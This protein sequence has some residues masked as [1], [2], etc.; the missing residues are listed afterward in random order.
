MIDLKIAIEK[1]EEE[2]KNDELCKEVKNRYFS[3]LINFGKLFDVYDL[4]ISTN[5]DHSV[6]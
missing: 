6:R 4:L 5:F 2:I 1:C 3:Y